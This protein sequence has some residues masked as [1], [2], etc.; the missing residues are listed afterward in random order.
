MKNYL[1]APFK[2]D[3]EKISAF[4]LLKD[5]LQYDNNQISDGDLILFIGRLESYYD[6]IISKL[7][8]QIKEN[9]ELKDSIFKADK[10]YAELSDKLQAENKELKAEIK[11]LRAD[12]THDSEVCYNLDDKHTDIIKRLND[13]NKK[14]LNEII[15]LQAEVKRG[16]KQY[17][18]L[19][20]SKTSH[21]PKEYKAEADEYFDNNPQC[22]KI[23]FFM[24]DGDAFDEDGDLM[25][26]SSVFCGDS[27]AEFNNINERGN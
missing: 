16:E 17:H 13:D 24:V 18:M 10:D 27:I 4:K 15:D 11:Q 21:Y 6:V 5:S 20:S 25:C 23:F 14:R 26:T 7:Q 19:A 8:G 3:D 1:F 2:N 12:M 9:K 22:E